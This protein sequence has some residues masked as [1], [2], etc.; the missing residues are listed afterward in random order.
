MYKILSKYGLAISVAVSVAMIALAVLIYSINSEAYILK[1]SGEIIHNT[2][3][4]SQ[5]DEGD[6]FVGDV[7]GLFQMGY[8]LVFIAVLSA[9]VVFP[10][11][12]LIANPK[13]GLPVV[14]GIVVVAIIYFVS[15]AISETTLTQTLLNLDNPPT[16]TDLNFTS[17]ILGTS[18]VLIIL[19][20]L[21]LIGSEIYK[22]VK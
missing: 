13:S 12:S 6:S 19:A 20:V 4:I 15:A 16:A 7:S 9:L 22:L 17:G 1:D 10:I 11:R 8:I 14:I 2:T 3:G 21:S 5:I 18:F